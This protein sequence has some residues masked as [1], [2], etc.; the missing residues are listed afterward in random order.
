M[1][2]KKAIFQNYQFNIYYEITNNSYKMVIDILSSRN[3][4]EHLHVFEVCKR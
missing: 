2:L 4:K 3:E 1:T